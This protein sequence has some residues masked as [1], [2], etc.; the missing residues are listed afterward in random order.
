[1]IEVKHKNISGPK[2]LYRRHSARVVTPG[3]RG[4]YMDVTAVNQLSFSKNPTKFATAWGCCF[5]HNQS[6]AEGS[7][8]DNWSLMESRSGA[9]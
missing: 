3:L 8:D 9:D 1:V 7:L 4:T 2:Y 6:Y 5:S